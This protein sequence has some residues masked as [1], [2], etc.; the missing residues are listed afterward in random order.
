LRLSNFCLVCG[1]ISRTSRP[2]Y[3]A[4]ACQCNMLLWHL[5]RNINQNYY[6]SDTKISD[7]NVSFCL[8]RFLLYMYIGTWIINVFYL[9]KNVTLLWSNNVFAVFDLPV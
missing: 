6:L 3:F 7:L 4:A 2:R 9:Q 8:I 1:I 5:V